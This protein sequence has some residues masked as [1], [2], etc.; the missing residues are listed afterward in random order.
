ML[1]LLNFIY[2]RWKIF[3]IKVVIWDQLWMLFPYMVELGGGKWLDHDL[4]SLGCWLCEIRSL[5][6]L[7]NP[8]SNCH[9]SEQSEIGQSIGDIEGRTLTD[10]CLTFGPHHNG[11]SSLTCS[12]SIFCCVPT[13]RVCSVKITFPLM[14]VPKGC[15]CQCRG[16]EL[17]CLFLVL[18]NLYLCSQG[19]QIF[20]DSQTHLQN[21]HVSNII[22]SQ[23]WKFRR[24]ADRDVLKASIQ[25]TVLH[26]LRTWNKIGFQHR[27]LVIAII[28][29]FAVHAICQTLCCPHDYN[30]W[31][32]TTVKQT[33]AITQW[34]K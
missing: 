10:S 30:P 33:S 8:W 7:V 3:I 29:I 6:L 4:S 23:I 34:K 26:Q 24:N 16:S 12:I 25:N 2:V 21:N 1:G 9:C 18:S 11:A 32:C 31:S 17:I 15:I 5:P 27:M 19:R 28:I 14:D 22:A 20:W 13:T